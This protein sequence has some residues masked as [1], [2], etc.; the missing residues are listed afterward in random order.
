MMTFLPAAAGLL[1]AA[2]VLFYKPDDCFMDKNRSKLKQ[3]KGEQHSSA[4]TAWRMT[5]DR[6]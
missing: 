2:A 6:S 5:L 4:K 3:R 1:S